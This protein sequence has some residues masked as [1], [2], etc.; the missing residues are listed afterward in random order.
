MTAES[1]SV[2]H[3][4]VCIQSKWPIGPE[5]IPVS[6][7]NRD[8]SISPWMGVTPSIEFAG[9]HLYTWVERGTLRVRCLA[10]EHKTMSPA[11]ARTQTTQSGD[12]RTNH[13][14]TALPNFINYDFEI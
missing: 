13:E 3:Y 14:V 2:N 8:K 11:R 7:V 4:L 10:Q 9:T 5:L 1:Y 12:E 6:V